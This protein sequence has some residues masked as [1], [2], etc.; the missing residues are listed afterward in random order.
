MKQIIK[1]WWKQY[2]IRKIWWRLAYQWEGESMKE[3]RQKLKRQSLGE[4][5]LIF[6]SV[7]AFFLFVFHLCF[8]LLKN[9]YSKTIDDDGTRNLI[10]FLAGTV[11]WY[12]LLRRTRASEQGVTVERLTRAMDQLAS[13]DLS[14]RLG[15]ILGLEQI[16]MLHEEE[17][18]KIMTIL[19]TRIHEL[20]Q[21]IKQ[22]RSLQEA[23]R[24][25]YP[26]GYPEQNKRKDIEIAVKAL[27]HILS[28]Y[29]PEHMMY[30]GLRDVDL[31]NL[32]F[33]G[34]DMSRFRLTNADISWSVMESANFS[35][36][37]L[38]RANLTHANVRYANF[39]HASL[40][41]GNLTE[42]FLHMGDLSGACLRGANLTSATLSEVDVS[43]AD[44]DDVKGLTQKQLDEAYYIKDY[45]PL[46]LPDGLKPPPERAK[47]E[48]PQIEPFSF[49]SV[50]KKS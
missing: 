7:F 25:E 42:I 13:E 45:P 14:I 12:F 23:A 9:G 27:S 47:K 1:N 41:G 15:G 19:T 22:D 46:N 24:L 31:Y 48:N 38:D 36:V 28:C 21:R 6:L 43:S 50:F 40:T 3:L 20:D 5:I 30:C 18:E 44:F 2:V 33:V 8:S 37:E 4:K 29:E 32:F 26:E 17:R 39:S 49:S 10:L 16:A 11:G 34:T 35:G